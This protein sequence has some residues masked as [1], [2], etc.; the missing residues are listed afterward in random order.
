MSIKPTL[1][2]IRWRR[3]LRA[4]G[5]LPEEAEMRQARKWV[6]VQAHLI[7]L[8]PLAAVF[9][10]RGFGARAMRPVIRAASASTV[11]DRNGCRV[12]A[13]H[14]NTS[15]RPTVKSPHAPRQTR[16][17]RQPG[18]RAGTAFPRLGRQGGVR[19]AQGR[20]PRRPGL[21]RRHAA[22]QA[23]EAQ[24]APGGGKPALGAAG[25]AALRALGRGHR[26]R[27][28]RLP[29]HQAEARG[30]AADRGGSAG[31]RPGLRQRSPRT[32]ST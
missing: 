28:P 3:Q 2:F 16:I 24:S 20:R 29:E 6:M 25:D 4:D 17:A 11:C 22:G 5:G 23:P 21:H 30:Q 31:R 9:L 27:R 14:D 7:A 12:V 10:A 8:I 13:R 1:M 18:R 15:A 19:V 32:A 26:H